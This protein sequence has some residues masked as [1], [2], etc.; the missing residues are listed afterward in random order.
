MN[1]V[2]WLAVD[3]MVSRAGNAPARSA[4]DICFTDSARSLRDYRLNEMVSPLGLAPRISCSQ[5]KRVSCY[6]TASLKWLRD[7]ESHTE[8]RAYE[9]W[10]ETP[11]SRR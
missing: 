2:L 11:P 9:A 6:T 7:C 3:E 1:M 4:K 8:S 5:G 10:L